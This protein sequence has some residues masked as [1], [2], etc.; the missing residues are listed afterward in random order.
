MMEIIIGGLY[1]LKEEEKDYD[2]EGEDYVVRVDRIHKDEECHF[3]CV[4][5]DDSGV[6]VG[7]SEL[8][9][10]IA[11]FTRWYEPYA[12]VLENE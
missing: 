11:D 5:S 6:E 9:L 12:Q 2:N 1:R 4:I 3:T 8:S 10:H 7:D